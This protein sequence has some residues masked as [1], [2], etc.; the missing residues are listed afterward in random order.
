MSWVEF[1]D[2]QFE[3]WAYVCDLYTILRSNFNDAFTQ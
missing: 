2:H 1:P 3:S